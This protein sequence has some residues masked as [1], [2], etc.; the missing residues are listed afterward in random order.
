[1]RT[2][3]LPG[4]FVRKLDDLGRVVLPVEWRRTF[5]IGPG[6]PM[7]IIPGRDGTLI[8]QRYVPGGTCTFCSEHVEICHFAGRPVCRSCAAQ[9][10]SL[11]Q[12]SA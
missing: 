9:L 8:L 2:A 11:A 1:V 3:L 7:E 12:P 4:G 5:S 6:A 10:G